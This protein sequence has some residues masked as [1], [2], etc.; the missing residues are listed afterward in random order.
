MTK[1]VNL[2]LFYFSNVCQDKKR[3][4]MKLFFP[5]TQP[6]GSLYASAINWWK[7]Y[8]RPLLFSL[9]ASLTVTFKKDWGQQQK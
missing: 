8:S 4:R 9:A 2:H 1:A 3:V 7:L 6:T 5:Y